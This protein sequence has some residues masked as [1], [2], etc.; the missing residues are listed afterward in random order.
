MARNKR[1]CFWY[2]CLKYYSGLYR[3]KQRNFS[4]QFNSYSHWYI[5]IITC[6]LTCSLMPVVDREL[7]HYFFTQIHR[8]CGKHCPLIS[9][10]KSG[11]RF[12]GPMLPEP[13]PLPTLTHRLRK[14]QCPLHNVKG[15]C[16]QC[17]S[18]SLNVHTTSRVLKSRGSQGLLGLLQD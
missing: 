7:F 10:F 17:L 11:G 2:Q 15:V 8:Q 1:N 12:Y 5:S 18:I 3:G 14:A 13:D 16:W 9:K 6:L 4:I